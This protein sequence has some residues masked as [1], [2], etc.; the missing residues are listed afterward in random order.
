MLANWDFGLHGLEKCVPMFVWKRRTAN[1]RIH[2]IIRKSVIF[3]GI[4]RLDGSFQPYGTAFIVGWK[5]KGYAINYLVTAK[6]VVEDMAATRRPRVG[7]INTKSG[8]AE[9]GNLSDGPWFYHPSIKNCDVAVSPFSGSQ[10]TFDFALVDVLENSLSDK[11]IS[12]NDIGCGDE[13]VTTGL[14]TNHFGAT[15]NV[16]IVRTGNIAAMPEEPVNLGPYG[17]QSVYLIESRSIGGLSGSPVFLNTPPFRVVN[18][19]IQSTAGQNRTYIMGVNIG[20]F[21]TLAL[22]DALPISELDNR[23]T[24]LESMSAGIS[25]V[26]PIQRV[27][28]ILEGDELENRRKIA[29]ENFEATSGFVATSAARELHHD[30]S[31]ANPRH[32]EDFTALVSKASRKTPPTD[33]T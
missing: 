10:D 11:Y 25:I 28:E 13:V 5:Y 20:L 32:Q 2:E 3:I 4:T 16:P 8:E 31:D 21:T 14:L 27:I 30:E 6:H 12:E 9:I 1:M 29:V 23:E 22:G 19:Q 15:R 26:V 18:H 17:F 24:I 33:Q 7:R